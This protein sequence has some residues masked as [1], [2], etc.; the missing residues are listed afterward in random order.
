MRISYWS[1]DVCSSDLDCL[2]D[3]IMCTDRDR[4]ERKDIGGL[5]G[6]EEPSREKAADHRD[7]ALQGS[8]AERIARRF[9]LHSEQESRC[10]RSDERRGGKECVSTCRSRRAPDM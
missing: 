8:G 7:G 4:G 9:L 1:S 5:E 10:D 2:E 3:R 6:K